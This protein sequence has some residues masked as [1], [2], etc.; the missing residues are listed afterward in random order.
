M[1][2]YDILWENRSKTEVKLQSTYFSIFNFFF[3]FLL[4]FSHVF[5]LVRK[6]ISASEFMVPYRTA[7]YCTVSVPI[8]ELKIDVLC[9]TLLAYVHAYVFSENNNE[10]KQRIISV[11]RPRA[12][13]I[14]VYVGTVRNYR[15][16]VTRINKK[17]TIRNEKA[18]FKLFRAE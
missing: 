6:R 12:D 3:Q 4:I 10:A 9:H 8:N 5:S 7:W 13:C 16:W 15:C 14:R 11:G 17:S 18:D 2:K 1:L